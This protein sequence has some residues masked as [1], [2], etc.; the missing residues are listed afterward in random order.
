MTARE[1]LMA[2][3]IG[4]VGLGRM[5]NPIGGRLLD[6]G[7]RLVVNDTRVDAIEALGRLG[8]TPAMSPSEVASAADTVLLSLPTPDVVES[9]VLGESGVAQGSRVRTIVDLSTTGPRTAKR[10][11]EKL[12]GTGVTWIDAPVSGGVGGAKAGTL[13]VMVSGPREVFERL[14]PMLKVIGKPFFIGEEP[15][16]AQ[17]MKVVNNLLSGSAMAISAEAVAIGVK[18]GLDAATMIDVINAGS[19]RNSATLEKFPRSILNRRF[20][21]G[22]AAG[23]MLKDIRLC[24]D[25]AEALGLSMPVA[26]AVRAL[27]QRTIDTLGPESDFTRI[28]E[29]VEKDAGVVVGKPS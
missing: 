7:Y 2:D 10:I 28:V 27:W 22:F 21:Y 19:G 13:A 8:A 29:T 6:S 5:G 11:A 9:V 3:V 4:F 17:M 15:G 12:S 23:L 25:E 24:L 18:A 1:G 20:D 26:N 16:L 14:Q